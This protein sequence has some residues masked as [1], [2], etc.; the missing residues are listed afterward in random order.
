MPERPLLLKLL[1]RERHWQNYG[2]FCAEYDKAATRID[3]DLAGSRVTKRATIATDSGGR[4]RTLTDGR[5]QVRRAAA[6]AARIC[7]WLRD[8]E[9]PD[10]IQSPHSRPGA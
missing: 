3:P 8:E 1:L 5:S 4:Q 7:C 9:A 10:S 2:T 6:L